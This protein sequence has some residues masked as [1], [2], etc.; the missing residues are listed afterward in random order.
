ME[1]CTLLSRLLAD[2]Q[3]SVGRKPASGKDGGQNQSRNERSQANSR[4]ERLEV[5]ASGAEN[6]ALTQAGWEP[7]E[8]P[9][10]D[11]FHAQ[12]SLISIQRIGW[13]S[14]W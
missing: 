9:G 2:C 10:P 7:R 1:Q 12:E 6:Q 5:R 13:W 3:E 11:G 8:C 14:H 4:P